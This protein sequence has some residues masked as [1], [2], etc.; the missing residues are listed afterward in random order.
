MWS[1]G[2]VARTFFFLNRFLQLLLILATKPPCKLLCL[3]L[4][5]LLE[6]RWYRCTCPLRSDIAFNLAFH[7]IA[8]PTAVA[9]PHPLYSCLPHIFPFL[10]NA[11]VPAPF[12]KLVGFKRVAGL[13]PGK[14]VTLGFNITPAQMTVRR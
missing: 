5:W 6:M 4:G 2:G 1:G 7:S 10:Q 9:L 13:T 8:T 12:V 11:T 3:I 14:A